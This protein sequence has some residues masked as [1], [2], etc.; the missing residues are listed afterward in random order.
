MRY[1]DGGG[2][3]AAHQARRVSCCCLWALIGNMRPGF[4]HDPARWESGFTVLARVRAETRGNARKGVPGL[5][6][7]DCHVC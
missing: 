6:C 7:A 4:Q 5:V 3:G 1:P 2:P